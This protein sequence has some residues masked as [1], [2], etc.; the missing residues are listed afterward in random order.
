[1]RTDTAVDFDWGGGSPD[2]SIP[3]ENFSAH[4]SGRG[5]ATVAGSYTF[6]TS[7]YDGVR[8][9]VNGVLAIDHW[10]DHGPTINITAPIAMSAGQRMDLQREYCERGGGETARLLWTP[11]GGAQQNIPQAQLW[12]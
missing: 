8:L 4:W 5:Q 7:S 6:A 12:K 9:W 3:V 2:P 10:T 1:M 11:P